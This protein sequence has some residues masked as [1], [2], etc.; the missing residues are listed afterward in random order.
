MD[1]QDFYGQGMK[2]PPTINPASG[3]FVVASG[4][5]SIR[6]ALYLILMT[7]RTERWLEPSFGSNMMSYTFI[8]TSPTML[9]IMKNDLTRTILEQEPRVSAVDITISPTGNTGVLRIDIKYA[10]ANSSTVDNLV[11]PFY[12]NATSVEEDEETPMEVFDDE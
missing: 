10:L 6:D 12:L 4:T 2:F 1:D 5:Q 3:R 7:R 11:F 9:G 8:D